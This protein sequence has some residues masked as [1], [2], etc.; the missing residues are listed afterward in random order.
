ML[1]W[2]RPGFDHHAL[3][4][5]MDLLLQ[6]AADTK[7]AQ[8][9]SYRDCFLQYLNIDPLLCPL[10]LLHD[11]IRQH[12]LLENKV[13]ELDHDSSLQ[14]LLAQ[15]I[16]PHL[17]IEAPLFLYDFPKTQAALSRIRHDDP[18][19]AE[20]FEVYIHGVEIANGFHELA[21]AEEQ[22]QRF[23]DNQQQREQLQIHVPTID[24]RL[25]AALEHGLPDC[26]GVALGVD[27]LL[28]LKTESRSIREVI[29]FHWENA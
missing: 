1:E 18:P 21:D 23:R 5:E 27:R 9:M 8:R 16:E 12:Q 13:D 25:I 17:G 20:R 3:M 4:D 11:L 24:Q 10:E 2:Y 15:L 28:M 6:T 19:V 26:A 14:L 22:S 7:P 29:A